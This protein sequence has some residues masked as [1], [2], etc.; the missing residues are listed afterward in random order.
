MAESSL[1]MYR[2]NVT[3]VMKLRY[4]IATVPYRC[5]VHSVSTKPSGHLRLMIGPSAPNR[6][7]GTAEEK[8]Y[9]TT[10]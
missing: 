7:I 9:T 4:S 2:N 8:A 3:N 10:P 1:I 6:S 5:L